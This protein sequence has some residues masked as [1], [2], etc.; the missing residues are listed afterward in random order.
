MGILFAFLAGL[1]ASSSNYCMRRSIDSGGSSSAY[2]V[3]QL[4]FSFLVMILLNPVRMHEFG[5]DNTVLTLGLIGGLLLGAFMWG[6]GKSLEKGP[7]GLTLAIVNASSIVPALVLTLLFGF[8][9]GHSYTL[10]NALGS[11]LVVI[12]IFWAGWTREKNS[13]SKSWPLYSIFVFVIHASYLVYLAWWAMLLT[14]DLPLGKLLPFHIQTSHIQ[15]FMPAVFF[16]AALFQW[17]A[18]LKGEKQIPKKSEII[19]GFLGG[20]TNGTC[21]FFL[22]KAPQVATSWQNAMLFPIF[23]VAIIISCN[24]WSQAIYKEKVNWKANA[25]CIT[26]LAIG[27]IVWHGL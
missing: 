25:L 6:L 27:T 13:Q 16:M 23:S 18:F 5:W 3:I 10:Y 24:I 7:A 17:G 21:A 12:G 14:S 8:K 26:G 19:Y 1:L 22:I 4:T 20:I 2:L 15:W 11:V 9:Y